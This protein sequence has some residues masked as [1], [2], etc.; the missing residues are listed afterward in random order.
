M[1]KKPEH[2]IL[3][4]FRPVSLTGDERIEGQ[5]IFFDTPQTLMFSA[6]FNFAKWSFVVSLKNQ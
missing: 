2:L 1:Q 6:F 3:Q 5:N 4:A